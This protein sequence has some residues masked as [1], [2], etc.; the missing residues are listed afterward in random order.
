MVS[1]G[2]FILNSC[3]SSYEFHFQGNGLQDNNANCHYWANRGE[4]TTNSRYMLHN[5][6]LS[7]ASHQGG[8]VWLI[9]KS[10]WFYLC[11]LSVLFSYVLKMIWMQTLI[12]K[13]SICSLLVTWTAGL[14]NQCKNWKSSSVM[15]GMWSLALHLALALALALKVIQCESKSNEI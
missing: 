3:L 13:I 2:S 4:C 7:C 10:T 14:K 5:C 1:V 8:N 11:P 15:V 12:I 9:E 6:K